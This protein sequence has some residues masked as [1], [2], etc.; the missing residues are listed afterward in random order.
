MVKRIVLVLCAIA[1]ML[2]VQWAYGQDASAQSA[3]GPAA[4]PVETKP[5]KPAQDKWEFEVV[6]YLWMSAMKGDVTLKG[7]EGSVNMSFSDIWNDLTFGAMLKIE[8]RKGRW[9]IFLDTV[10]MNLEDNI[11]GK[12]TFTGPQGQRTAEILADADISM[13]Q[14]V[15]E[16]GGFYELTKTP[17]G[18]DKDK[19]M[20]LDL[21]VGGRYWYL[22]TDVDVGLVLDANRNTIARNIS[23]SGSKDWIDPFVGL[24]TRIQLTEKL[25]L[26][27]RGDIGGFGV[28]SDFSWNAAG[29]FGYRA[30]EM[31]SLWAG[32]HALGV[33]YKSGGGNSKIVYDM[34]FQGPVLVVGFRF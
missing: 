15:L 8:A 7:I 21:L 1:I 10:Y 25:M 11:Q 29:Y 12:R 6:P 18:Q 20:Y 9:G 13:E 30:S 5:V 22:S 31:I 27:L 16:F 24:R 32:Y 2:S 33:D 34:I 26:V 4:S 3:P 17:V 14:W 28:G 23:K 19:M